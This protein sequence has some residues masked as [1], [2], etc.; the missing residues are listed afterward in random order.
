MEYALTLLLVAFALMLTG[1]GAYS[2]AGILPEPL[3]K[4]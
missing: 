2:L 4:L 3:R 1:P